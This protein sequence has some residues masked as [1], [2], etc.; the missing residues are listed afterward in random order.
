MRHGSILLTVQVPSP[1]GSE[2]QLVQ[3]S[4]LISATAIGKGFLGAIS[5]FKQRVY[6]GAY[7]KT[8]DSLIPSIETETDRDTLQ[9]DRDENNTKVEELKNS[10]TQSRS[11]HSQ[12]ES[13]TETEPIPDAVDDRGPTILPNCEQELVQDSDVK[14]LEEKMAADVELDKAVSLARD[15][16]NTKGEELNNS[17]T[18]KRSENSQDESSTETE[19]IPDAVDDRGPTILPNCKQELVQDSDVKGLE[20][21]MAADVELDKAVSLAFRLEEMEDETKKEKCA[22]DDDETAQH[23]VLIVHGIGEMLLKFDLFGISK[24]PTIDDCCG[25]LRKNHEEVLNVRFSQMY[26]TLDGMQQPRRGRVE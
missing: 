7:H 1:D 13:S 15:E 21:K 9:N 25:F 23:L 14:G 24:V 19:P 26:Q 16:N 6:R 10:S 11:E 3:F 17:S 2:N 8:S 18:Q 20:E 5:L 22:D 4:S 12:D